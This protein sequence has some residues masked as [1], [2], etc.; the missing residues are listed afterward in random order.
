MI[1]DGLAQSGGTLI[2]SA[3]AI[4]EAGASKASSQY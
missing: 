1:V 2:S 4:K 3:N